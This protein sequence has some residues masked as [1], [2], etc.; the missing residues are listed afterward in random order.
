M[1]K[2][3]HALDDESLRTLL[4]EIECIIN[5]RPLTVPSSDPRD[6]D[7]LTPSHLLTVKSKIVMSPPGNFQK[8]DVYLRRRWKRVQYLSNVFWSRWK[9]EYVQNLQERAKWNSPR[10][11]LEKG[12]LVLIAD[13]RLPRNR[14]NMARVVDVHPD[15][16]GRVRSVKVAMAT[17]T[18][19]RPIQKLVLIL[20]NKEE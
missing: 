5:S 6:L 20:E 12:D 18:L 1:R 9:K 7:P 19:E 2:H 10:R 8:T 11:N 13:D 16:K 17:T 4:A 14:W 15:S 3:G